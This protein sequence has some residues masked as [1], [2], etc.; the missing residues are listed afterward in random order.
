MATNQI[1]IQ[2]ALAPVYPDPPGYCGECGVNVIYQTLPENPNVGWETKAFGTTSKHLYSSVPNYYPVQRITRPVGTLYEHDFS[3]MFNGGAS[4]GKR[5]SY[6]PKYYPFTNR[7]VR[8]FREYDDVIL[9]YMDWRAWTKHPVKRDSS[10][11]SPL[12]NYPNPY[13]PERTGY[14]DR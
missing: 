1:A 10:V 2:N 9:P 13:I 8:E 11:N 14:G 12:H 6:Q 4:Y 5:M 3:Q 7:N